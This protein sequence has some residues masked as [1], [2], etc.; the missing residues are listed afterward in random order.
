M[1]HGQCGVCVRFRSILR[2]VNILALIFMGMAGCG[3]ELE[4]LSDSQLQDRSYQ[5]AQA[6]EQTPGQAISCDNYR[7]ECQ[8]R[9]DLG[10]YV[11]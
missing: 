10:R 7:R 6:T 5:C 4:A 11:C 1:A 2:P 3:N 8:R 9:R